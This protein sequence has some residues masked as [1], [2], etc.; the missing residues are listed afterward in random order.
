Q[1]KLR[2]SNQGKE[3][4]QLEYLAAIVQQSGEDWSNVALI[5]STAQPM[6]NAAPPELKML[7]VTVVPRS[8]A[9]GLAGSRRK[10]DG[11]AGFA[12]NSSPEAIVQQAQTLRGKAQKEYKFNNTM[13][14]SKLYNEAAA[15]EQQRDLLQSKDEVFIAGKGRAGHSSTD[16]GPSVTY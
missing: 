15:L 9:P 3:P 8:S 13:D 4:V 5:L 16:E 1:Y 2:G 7:E 12:P 14:D 11:Y 6:L 10:A